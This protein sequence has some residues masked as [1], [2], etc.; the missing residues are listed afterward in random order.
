MEKKRNTQKKEI[1]TLNGPVYNASSF[2][3]DD[4][5]GLLLRK[6]ADAEVCYRYVPASELMNP[7]QTESVDKLL[8]GY[9]KNNKSKKKAENLIIAHPTAYQKIPNSFKVGFI[10]IKNLT[11]GEIIP[12][13][14][15]YDYIVDEEASA[16]DIAHQ[17]IVNQGQ[18]LNGKPCRWFLKKGKILEDFFHKG[19]AISFLGQTGCGKMTCID[20][21]AKVHKA[22]L[23][24]LRYYRTETG[25]LL[26]REIPKMSS[27]NSERMGEIQAS[28]QLQPWTIAVAL[29]AHQFLYEYQSEKTLFIDGSPRKV[30]EVI[31]FMDM[32][33]HYAKKE[34]I[35]FH[36]VITDEAAAERSGIR[37]QELIDA[38]KKIRPETSTK[39]SLRKKLAYYSTDI[40]PALQAMKSE[41]GVTIYVIDGMQSKEKVTDDIIAR[42]VEYQL[43]R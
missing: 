15:H 9:V 2:M 31:P 28:G 22:L 25:N 42:I 20:I 36:I 13:Y 21:L 30:M 16:E 18:W 14:D 17:I 37:N 34:I 23:P 1:I 19:Q 32:Y 41:K 35:V 10:S 3:K 11:D 43:T 40:L 38:G 29:W 5:A 7:L 39:Q 33:H 6:F 24:A 8:L 12:L 27:F 26:R 4:V